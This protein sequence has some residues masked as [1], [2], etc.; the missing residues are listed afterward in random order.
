MRWSDGEPLT[1]DD[2]LFTWN[3]VIYNTN[4]DNVT[5]DGFIIDGKKFTIS[6]IDDLTIQVV[7]PTT[8]A[9]FLA[10]FAA[11]VEI[12]PKH[13][14]SKAVA[15]GTFTSAYGVN[16]DPAT[17][18]GSGPYR[19]KECKAA[20]YTRLER[21]PY[22]FET[23]KK[24]QRLPYFDTVIFTVVPNFNAMSLRFLS[25]ES[26]ADDYIYANEYEHF[27]EE[28]KKEK[29]KLLESG[30]G[31][32]M[33]FFWLNQNTNMNAKTGQ[34]IVE[35]KK[36]K[37]FRDLKFRQACSYAIDRESIIKSVYSGRGIPSYGFETAG[38][39]K[40]FNPD[41]R[42]YPHDIDKAKALLKEIGIEKR[43]GDEFATDADGN[44]IEFV[45][46][47]NTGNDSR[48]QGGDAHSCGFEGTWFPRHFPANRIQH[49][50]FP[51]LTTPMI[52]IV[53]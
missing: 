35:A 36:L 37:W 1:A 42:K 18:I 14:L 19:L 51:K 48:G 11:G 3:D 29:F 41:I 6:K 8:F 12:L 38:N 50:S 31:L 47:T 17:V 45:L 46:N 49:A 2:V 30:I 32:E 44:K 24:G 40:W 20:Q 33:N 34:P 25:G 13:I 43:N 27:K 26:D 53:S 4:I 21:N 15:K 23:D 28:A 9:P 22:Y 10:T 7:T 52:T 16:S 39:V 5:R